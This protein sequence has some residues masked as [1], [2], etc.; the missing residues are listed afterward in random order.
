MACLEVLTAASVAGAVVFGIGRN[1]CRSQVH[2]WATRSKAIHVEELLMRHKGLQI[3]A[4]LRLASFLPFGA[5]SYALSVTSVRFRDYFL[6][7]IAG[8][9]PFVVVEVSAGGSLTSLS[10][11]TAADSPPEAASKTSSS[12][13]IAL[14]AVSFLVTLFTSIY[15]TR[16]ARAELAAMR[17]RHA[18]S[19]I[20]RLDAFAV[21]KDV[22]TSAPATT[23]VSLQPTSAT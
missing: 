3:V 21:E 15:I 4:L 1:A 10:S 5:T 17:E 2:R 13:Q 7:T 23:V 22:T 20:Q 18:R 14:L 8:L 11:A 19:Q 6:G 9:L 16:M 12:V